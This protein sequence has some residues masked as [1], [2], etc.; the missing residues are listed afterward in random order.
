MQ[1][2]NQTVFKN[3]IWRF[4]E[5][6]GAQGVSLVVS[7]VLARIL[8]PDVYGTVALISVFQ[9]ILDVF[10][11]SGLGNALIQKKNADDDDF[12]TVF[13]FNI[14]WCV[15]LYCLLYVAS[16]LAAEFYND[17]S[18]VPLLRVA[19]ITVLISGVKNIQLAYVSRTMQFKKFFWATLGGTVFSGIVGIL[20][21]YK[22]FGAWAL[23][24]QSV[25]NTAIDTCILW[26]SVKWRPTGRFRFDRLKRLF[27]YGWKLLVSALLDRLYMNL[28]SLIIGKKYTT[29]DLA[30]YNK[31]NSW[32]ELIVTNINSSIDSV[33]LPTMSSEQDNRIRVKQMTRRAISISTYVMAP[34]MLGLF[35]VAPSLVSFLLTD[36]WLPIVPYMRIFC[37]TYLFYPIHTAN[38]NAIK[39]MG[40]SNLF[41][42]LEI[43]KKI[44]G[45]AV[46]FSTMW[47]GPMIMAYS[48]LFVSL[49]SQVINTW[50]NRKLMDYSY[51][52]QLKDIMPNIMM[53]VFMGAI[54][55]I[56]PVFGF[57]SIVT[58]VIQV[59]LG[60]VV[61]IGISFTLKNENFLYLWGIIKPIVFRLI[62]K[63]DMGGDV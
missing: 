8:A 37:I 43:I 17:R 53:A 47:F 32:P 33:L 26:I 49:S 54:V 10:V 34:M 51:I 29:E 55:S 39:A 58:L 15:I 38:L 16:P 59:P 13:C 14:I 50:P 20:L 6:V 24:M 5:R 61:Y 63:E 52:E 19:G 9:T 4:A 40:R 1:I 60:A 23:V 3:L 11:D 36:K 46:L 21:A 57:T 25:T 30:Y 28:R 18:L 22:G 48:L 45:L 2:N 42:K 31:G 44:V 62:K 56:V 41:L 12:T 27:S 7:I 35:C